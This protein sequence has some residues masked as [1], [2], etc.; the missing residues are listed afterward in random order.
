[1]AEEGLRQDLSEE[2]FRNSFDHLV[3]RQV[4]WGAFTPNRKLVSMA[5]LNTKAKDIGQVGGVYT[6]PAFRGKGIAKSL[7][8]RMICDVQTI[9]KIN[10]L[11]L[12]TGE[13]NLAAQRL[14]EG[15]KF[16]R[17][18]QFGLIFA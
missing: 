16:S 14:Y 9:H 10:R 15:L 3:K 6:A 11:I 8:R 7:M 18:G 1:L 12:F 5:G 4:V 17:C 13:K 2:D